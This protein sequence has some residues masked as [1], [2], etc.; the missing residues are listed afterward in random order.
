MENSY[1]QINITWEGVGTIYAGTPLDAN[2]KIA[3]NETAVGILAEDLNTPNRT[4]IVLTA[5][6]WD[7]DVNRGRIVIRNCVKKK[8]SNIKFK[9]GPFSIVAGGRVGSLDDSLLASEVII[10]VIGIP[11]YVSDVAEYDD[12]GLTETGWYTFTRIKAKNG[13]KVTA[14]TTVT[15]AAGSIRTIG[16]DHVDVAVRFEVA[17]QSKRVTVNWGA[18]SDTFVFRATDLA[19]R[20]LDYRTTFYIYDIAKYVTWEYV[21]TADTAFAEGKRYFVKSGNAFIQADV[22]TKA[23]VLTEDATFQSGKTYYILVDEEYTAAEVTAGDAVTANTYYEQTTVAVPA[24]YVDQYTLTDDATFQDG[25]TYYTESGGVYSEATVTT[26]DD[27]PADTYYEHAY[28]QAEGLF[29]DGMTYYTKSGDTYSEATVTT[30]DQ[31]PAYYN[32]SKLTFAGMIRNVTYR[33]NEMVDCPI[34]IVLPVVPDDG[35]GAWFEIQMQFNAQYSITLVPTDNTVKIGTAI[36]QSLTAGINVVD[37]TYSA[38]N[39]IKMWTLLNT[40]S[41]LPVAAGSG[42]ASMSTT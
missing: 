25:K 7:E 32:H 29:E 26:G 4:A 35:Y 30:G 27:V 11:T 42:G 41:N 12:Y 18:T 28:A 24:Y 34:E 14:G 13:E 38:V 31:I 22:E 23:Y 20:N 10:D 19:V 36:T 1:I 37:L 9:R 33:L 6:E 21:F 2:G 39:E 8:L 3:N 5:G 40:H 15:G 16:E 17:A